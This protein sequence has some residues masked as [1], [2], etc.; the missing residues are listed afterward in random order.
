MSFDLDTLYKLLPAIYRIRDLQQLSGDTSLLGQAP[1]TDQ[2]K[3]AMPL[4]ALMEVFG[5]QIAVLEENLAQLYDDQFIETCADWA[6]PYIGELV[7]YT[8]PH[9]TSSQSLR[10]E[11]AHTIRYRKRKGTITLLEQLVRDVTGWDVHVVEYFQL[12]ATT[13]HLLRL[14]PENSLID[15][16]QIASPKDIYPPSPI[17]KPVSSED[18]YPPSPFEKLVHTVDVRNIATGGGRYNIANIG[19]F[20][21][22]LQDYRLSNVPLTEA[23]IKD[24]NRYLYFF[25]PLGSNLQL[26]THPQHQENVTLPDGPPSVAA[27]IS[28]TM[29]ART[30]SDYYG[31]DKSFWFSVSEKTSDGQIINK[32]ILPD[33]LELLIEISNVLY[34]GLTSGRLDFQQLAQLSKA[35]YTGLTTLETIDFAQR[36]QLID[37]SETLATGLATIEKL[38][39]QTLAGLITKSQ[40]LFNGLKALS[41]ETD[42]LTYSFSICDLSDLTTKETKKEDEDKESDEEQ[43]QEQEQE[44]E[45]DKDKSDWKPSPRGTIAIDP[46]LGRVAFPKRKKGQRKNIKPLANLQ[47][48]FSYGFSA[49]MGGGGYHRGDSFTQGLPALQQVLAK[50]D[51]VQ[52]ALDALAVSMVDG[53]VEIID[54]GR[55]EGILQIK[56]G[57]NQRIELRAENFKRPLLVLADKKARSESATTGD[58]GAMNKPVLAISGDE[59][60]EVTINGLVISHGP[61]HVTGKLHRLTI[62]HCTLVPRKDIDEQ[63]KAQEH[64][65][66]G[67]ICESNDTT[68][69]IDHSIVGR[70][71]VKGN[72]KVQIAN[73]IVDAINQKDLAYA[74]P[75]AFSSED[76]ALD[77]LSI[78]NST[79]IGRV[80]TT[81]L[82]LASNTIFYTS[83][84]ENEATVPVQVER[85]QEG[86]VRYSYLPDGSQ[87]P[88]RRYSCQ[89]K[90]DGDAQAIE[91]HFTSRTYGDASYCQLSQRTSQVILSGA[92]D[93]A[94]M[95]AFHDLFQP[96]RASNLNL[97][98]REYLRFGF[99]T[100]IFYRT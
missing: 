77:T 70:L 74:G 13:Q 37:W 22:R 38:D 78:E 36:A 45:N 52:K 79:I 86:C 12:L 17:E 1:A 2:N 95:G 47:A 33:T 55:M 26:F 59:G 64:S 89:P 21:W 85:R 8:L 4:Q 80:H 57:P 46:V 81:V 53:I 6:I 94:E 62:S 50:L 7:G 73:S 44:Q 60:A 28:R 10:S 35:L 84:D 25:N 76:I 72:V 9:D 56:S 68:I 87:V 91:L 99:E 41:K 30:F 65:L 75:P 58:Q 11:V 97:R 88:Q 71:E 24:R 69:V 40:R 5:E 42:E 16:R 90:K 61:I 54:N 15:V 43:E 3:F 66:P 67:L 96:Q 82:E 20:I 27:P 63:G 34:V 19:I 51:D 93:K 100:G 98:L 18:V 14:R 32:P 48:T 83:R 39:F 49:D 29:L 92:D 23:H 31:P